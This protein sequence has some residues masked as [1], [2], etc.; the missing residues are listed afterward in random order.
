M[1][2]RIAAGAV[3]ATLISAVSC[4]LPATPA[5]AAAGAGVSAGAAT[6]GSSVRADF[7]GDG[8]ADLAV[9]SPDEDLTVGFGGA[10]VENGGA[11]NVIYGTRSAGL[12]APKDQFWTQNS[13]GMAEEA[14]PNDRFGSALAAGDFNGDRYSDLAVGVPFE[15][16]AGAGDAEGVVHVIF[17]S[18]NG[19]T[20]AKNQLWSQNSPGV[21]EESEYFDRFGSS[22]AVGNLGRSSHDDLAIGVPAEDVTVAG[23]PVMDAG[24]VNV[25]YGSKTGLKATTTDPVWTQ[26]TKGIAETAEPFDQ[27]GSVLTIGDF[28][29]SAHDDL[30]VSAPTEAS[31]PKGVHVVYGTST[32]LDAKHSQWWTQASKDMRAEDECCDG[33]GLSLAAGNLGHSAHDDLAIGSPYEE[34]GA[35]SQGSVNVIYGTKDGLRAAHNQLWSQDSAGIAGSGESG[36]QFGYALAIG[37]FGKS[38][39]EDLA[40][41]VPYEDVHAVDDGGVNVIYGSAGGLTAT[42]D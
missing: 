40:I 8:V 28:G 16:L 24:A 31:G 10:E 1:R 23:Q 32:G 41:G 13:D 15:G 12:Q 20:A 9:G 36:D 25:L 7:N 26:Q 5:T 19:L 21:G 14:E 42:G 29:R 11:V 17:G 22:L 39:H 30:A 6:G 18:K 27:F 34:L 33:F 37:N 35:A 3:A 4:V 2:S 38:G